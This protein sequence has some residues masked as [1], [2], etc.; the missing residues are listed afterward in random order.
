MGTTVKEL[1]KL[2]DW[3]TELKITD[4]AMALAHLLLRIIYQMLKTKKH[5]KNLV[6][7]IFQVKKGR[8]NI[9]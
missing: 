8:K 1:L 3:L 7:T 2:Q 6:G 5:T 4:I 9:L